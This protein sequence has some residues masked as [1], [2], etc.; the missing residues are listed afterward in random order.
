MDDL[1]IACP[2]CLDIIEEAVSLNCLHSLCLKCATK[3][4][5]E[6]D[7]ICPICLNPTK[8]TDNITDLPPNLPL[9][10]L[11]SALQNGSLLLP[12]QEAT[13]E[14]C[15]EERASVEC[16]SCSRD[17]SS[18]VGYCE[19]CFVEVHTKG[20]YLQHTRAPLGSGRKVHTR[21]K[22]H[23]KDEDLYCTADK[24]IICIYCLQFEGHREHP[25]L[26]LKEAALHVSKSYEGLLQEGLQKREHLKKT[27]TYFLE[28]I[29][30]LDIVF[31]SLNFVK[32]SFFIFLFL[33]NFFFFS[34][35]SKKKDFE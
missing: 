26:P 15:G 18:F 17:S 22:K 25:C 8:L 13:C 4:S 12:S 3:I 24:R 23:G 35:F 16:E 27:A 28:E 6:G 9:R 7:L 21:C 30:R 32:N 19:G 10:H 29:N 11:L 34:F 14:R 31:Y 5:S 33:F 20:P 1:M 2:Y